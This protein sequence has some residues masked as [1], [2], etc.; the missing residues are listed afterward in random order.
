VL[1]G[2]GI[3][4][5]F[6]IAIDPENLPDR[7]FHVGQAGNFLYCS[8][9]LNL[10]GLRDF[11]SLTHPDSFPSGWYGSNLAE[12]TAPKNPPQPNSTINHFNEIGAVSPVQKAGLGCLIPSG[13]R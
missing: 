7:H 8:S 9:Q 5:H 3:G 11:A 10:R 6:H 1:I 2:L 13:V 4:R 12:A